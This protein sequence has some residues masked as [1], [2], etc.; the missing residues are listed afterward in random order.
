[1][2]RLDE[3]GRQVN[4]SMRGRG[5]RGDV[6]QDFIFRAANPSGFATGHYIS[7]CKRFH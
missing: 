1:V 5:V 6:D 4:Q 2:D 3:L 7:T